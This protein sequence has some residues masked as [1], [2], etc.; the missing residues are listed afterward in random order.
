MVVNPD[1]L[2]ARTLKSITALVQKPF[3]ELKEAVEKKEQAVR[4]WADLTEALGTTTIHFP[5]ARKMRPCLIL[6]T[7]GNKPKACSM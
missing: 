4:K 6:Q 2:K 1:K 5:R 3:K 7:A